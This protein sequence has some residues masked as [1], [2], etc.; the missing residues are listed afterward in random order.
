M[1]VRLVSFVAD[2][3]KVWR[4]VQ[5]TKHGV[6]LAACPIDVLNKE[7]PTQ[8]DKAADF[9]SIFARNSQLNQRDHQSLSKSP[10]FAGCSCN[11][12]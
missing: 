5:E 11:S 9:V 3:Q 10:V 4:K 12:D 1:S 6:Q 7:W 8:A 2:L